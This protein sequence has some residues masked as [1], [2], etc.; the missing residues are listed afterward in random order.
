MKQNSTPK[1][2]EEFGSYAFF[3][4]LIALAGLTWAPPQFAIFLWPLEIGSVA[5]MILSCLTEINSGSPLERLFVILIQIA[6]AGAFLLVFGTQRVWL[7]LLVQ[8]LA[9]GGGLALIEYQ[10]EQKQ[11]SVVIE[12]PSK[13]MP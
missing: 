4:W 9:F 3:S 13:Q 8:G 6:A 1:W 11:T 7:T 5:M 10:S 2:L 12:V